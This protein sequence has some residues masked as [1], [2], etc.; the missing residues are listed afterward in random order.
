LTDFSPE[1]WKIVANF[2]TLH[3]SGLVA[4]QPRQLLGAAMFRCVSVFVL[5]L[6]LLAGSVCAADGDGG[7]SPD[8]IKT[9]ISSIPIDART[10]AAINAVT[11]NDIKEL[12]LNRDIVTV[13]DDIFSFKLPTKGVT[14]QES[15]GRCW[16]F[17]GLNVMRQNVIKKY[18]LDDFELSQSYLAF[19]DKFEKSN[20]F[21]EF[22]IET[23]SRDILD[24]ELD[25]MLDQPI[26]DGG[27]WDYVVN[28][29]GKYGVV[30][31]K[32]MGETKS[33][34]STGRMDYILTLLLRRDAATLRKM[35]ADGKSV[36]QL[37]QEKMTMLKDVLKV[38]I[39]NYGVPP[40]SFAWRAVDDSTHKISDAVTYTPQSFY[41]D[42]VGINLKEYVSIGSYANHPFGVNYSINLTRSMADRSDVSFVNLDPAKMKEIAL[43]ALLDSN[44]VWFGCDM[45]NDVHGKKGLMIKG[46]FDYESLFGVPLQMSKQELLDMRHSSSNHAMVLTGV[47]MVNAKPARWKVENSWGK[48]RGDG[49]FFTMSDDWFD[50]YVLNVVVPK[51]Y[52]TP[53][54]LSIAQQKPTPLPVWDPVW[55]SM[56]W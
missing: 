50:Q 13:N 31:K 21:L 43:K 35:A 26:G 56:Q 45:G 37:R 38:L 20:V 51:A 42:V 29:V 8:Q 41:R 5:A 34:A 44:R 11:N 54:V 6:C 40:T 25:K 55:R 19:W 14:D 12:A 22:I 10:K 7:L 9:L 23:R 27:Y 3:L 30:P 39:I 52:V 16:M 28:I 1:Y 33:S 4:H 24:R 46:L 15:S 17:A 53:D 18:S 32:F 49:G 48:D 36:A 47:D 2:P